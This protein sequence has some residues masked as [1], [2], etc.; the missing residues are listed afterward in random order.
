MLKNGE[1]MSVFAVVVVI[2]N[3]KGTLLTSR[4]AK[5]DNFGFP[6][7]KVDPGETPLEAARRELKE[8]TGL[9]GFNFELVY[10]AP[11]VTSGGRIVAVY[12]ADVDIDQNLQPE[13]GINVIW[14]DIM[15]TVK[16]DS[17][18][19]VFNAILLTRI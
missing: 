3:S 16:E 10:S 17:A 7:G 4:R 1:V 19:K 15:Q 13:E 8:E 11:E 2:R 18:F 5:P 6:G 9:D 14:G 12:T